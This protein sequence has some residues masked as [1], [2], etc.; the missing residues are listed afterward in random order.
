MRASPTIID[1]PLYVYDVETFY[2]TFLF[3]GSFDGCGEAQ[4]FELS[5]RKN[6]KQE[7]LNFLNYLKQIDAFMVG[8][9][10]LG[11]D[12]PIIHD[13]MMNPMLFDAKRA[14]DTA[15]KIIDEQKFKIGFGSFNIGLHNREIHQVDLMK[16]WHFDNDSKRT[17]LKDLQFAMRSPDVMDLPYDFRKPLSSEQIDHLITYNIHDVSETKKFLNFTAE[18][19]KLRRDLLVSQTL[20]GDVLNWND[21]KIGEEF[22]ISKIG[23]DICYEGRK[24]RGTDRLMVDFNNIILPPSSNLIALCNN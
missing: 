14:F 2:D 17:R 8:Y 16:I 24:P 1:K 18:R 23:R 20:K 4:V 22:F 6:Q 5:W 10:N 19:L 11:F 21:T 12:Y 15:Q 13:L 3:A 7:L 9:N